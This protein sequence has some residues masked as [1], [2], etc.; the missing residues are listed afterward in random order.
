MRWLKPKKLKNKNQVRTYHLVQIS[1]EKKIYH[2]IKNLKSKLLKFQL[3]CMKN[4]NSSLML[5]LSK[6]KKQSSKVNI[7]SEN[8]N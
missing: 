2:Q 6:L 1:Q 8:W 4:L 3:Q 5:I 7:W